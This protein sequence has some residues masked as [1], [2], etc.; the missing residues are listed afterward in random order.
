MLSRRKQASDILQH[1][2]LIKTLN[3][4]GIKINLTISTS[5]TP[6]TNIILNGKKLNAFLLKL[7]M[8]QG[9]LLST[10]LQHIVL[11]A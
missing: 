7:G 10:L 8:R 6:T 3:E 2:F 4:L 5:Q 9:C 11:E 1:L